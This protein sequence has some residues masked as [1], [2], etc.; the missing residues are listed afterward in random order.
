MNFKDRPC[1]GTTRICLY[2]ELQDTFA[3]PELKALRG[4]SSTTQDGMAITCAAP[5]LGL[6]DTLF[7]L[8]AED[9][10]DVTSML[11]GVSGYPQHLEMPILQGKTWS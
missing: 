10:Q 9:L 5:H 8:P 4:G 1:Q 11:D 3:H 2:G 6:G 7:V